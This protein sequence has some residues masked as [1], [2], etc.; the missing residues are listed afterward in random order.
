MTELIPGT[1]L[2]EPSTHGAGAW[3]TIKLALT[4]REVDFTTGPVGRAIVLLAIPMVLEMAM[5]SVFALTDAFFVSRLGTDAVATVG[6]TEAM[7][8]LVF[9]VAIGAGM[10][11]TAMVARRIGEK[12]RRGA[13]LAAA[14][15]IL[16]GVLLSAAVAVPGVLFAAD[17]LRLMG[18]TPE[19]VASGQG[20]TRVLFGGSATI[21]LIFLLNAVFRGAGDAAIAMHVLWIA[22]LCNIVLDPCLIFGLGPFPEMGVT[23]AAVATTIGRG[24]GVAIQLWVLVRGRSRIALR[25]P[26]L[27][28][29]LRL[30]LG[31]LRLSVG[32]ILQLLIGTASWVLLVWIIGS[33]GSAAVAG[34]TI[35]IRLVVFAILPSWGLANAAATLVG[36]NLGAGQAARAEASVWRA[37]LYNMLFL[38]AVALVF[39][40]AAGPLIRIF[41]LEPEVVAFGTSCLV[42][43]SI[44]Y[45]MY[46]WGMVM[47]QA[48]N[49]AGDT[50][51]P[52]VI[53]FCCYWL[54]QLPLAW[55]LAHR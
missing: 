19:L 7:I 14:Q 17:L 28:P 45:P 48:F 44:G 10:A 26:D 23:G 25:W 34:Y 53:N 24:L 30:I 46:A 2:P 5:E 51:T 4:G 21:M 32:G 6:L 40:A 52:T 38:L 18:G 47:V 15:S 36:Q 43:V 55:V 29:R 49:G 8:S 41:T 50:Y 1:G 27:V 13:D 31:L 9:A 35:A 42:L 20:Y 39:I 22:N 33:F 11:T 37:G 54:F 3:A 16:L 12:D